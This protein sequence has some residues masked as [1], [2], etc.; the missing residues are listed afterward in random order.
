MTLPV[1]MAVRKS[2]ELVIPNSNFENAPNFVAKTT[3]SSSWI[4]GQGAGSQTNDKNGWHFLPSNGQVS[5]DTTQTP[6]PLFGYNSMHL[7]ITGTNNS[8]AVSCY[9]GFSLNQYGI[10][11][12]P[13]T[14]YTYKYFM[15]TQL[16]SGTSGS[17]NGAGIQWLERDASGSLVGS[18][19]NIAV[20]TTQGW[21][22]YTDSH[23][24][25]STAAWL[26]PKLIIIG[27]GGAHDI[28]MEAWF[29][30]LRGFEG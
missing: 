30:R 6:S 9:P 13:N 20:S 10:P 29:K 28:L 27:T 17:G 18:A 14:L 26:T 11:I 12:K 15:K 5:F 3:A 24:S 16:N 21:N 23:V 7:E 8:P 1:R 4:N 25:A 2:N 22:L 19:A